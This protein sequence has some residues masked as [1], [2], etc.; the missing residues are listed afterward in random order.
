MQ[1]IAEGATYASAMMMAE[2]NV[3]SSYLHRANTHGSVEFSPQTQMAAE[4]INWLL[5][6][7]STLEWKAVHLT[8]H[9]FQDTEP[10]EE[11]WTL[12]QSQYPGAPIEAFRDPHSPIIEGH[13][14]IL[15]KNGTHYYP[16]AAKA[17]VPYL[18]KLEADEVPRELWPPHL[19]NIGLNESKFEK[20]IDKI[21]HGRMLGLVAVGGAILATRG[22]KV[23]ATTMA[24]Y[25]PAVLMLGGGVNMMG[26]TGQ[27]ENEIERLRVIFGKQ[28]AIPDA[29]GSYAS[30]FFKWLAFFTAGEANHGDH[31]RDPG[32]PFLTSENNPLRDPSSAILKELAKHSLNGEALVFFPGKSQDSSNQIVS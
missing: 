27:V 23:A 29:D 15:F 8:H 17:I 6:G 2:G 12:L 31:H 14:N 18:R 22:P 30:N 10:T 28:A 3:M 4:V 1:V 13:L 32:N 11:Q 20:T 24:S 21:P 7:M 16:R 5:S 26:H 25:I 9:A 19:R